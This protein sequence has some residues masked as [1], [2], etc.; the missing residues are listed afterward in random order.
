[1]MSET[2][3]YRPRNLGDGADWVGTVKTIKESNFSKP[4]KYIEIITNMRK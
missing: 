4:T 3:L 2:G 1:M